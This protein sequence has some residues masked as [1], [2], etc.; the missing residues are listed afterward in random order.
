VKEGQYYYYFVV[1]GKIRFSPEQPTATKMD[2]IV[3]FI[4]IDKY[5]ILKAEEAR[6]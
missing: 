1:D 3:N 2:R 5:M 6:D 4:E